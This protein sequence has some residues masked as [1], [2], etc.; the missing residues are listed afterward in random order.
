MS[1]DPQGSPVPAVLRQRDL[2]QDIGRSLS[3]LVAGTS[4]VV[5]LS[6]RSLAGYA[7]EAT[8]VVGEDGSR[9]SVL[10]PEAVTDTLEALRAVMY[11]EDSGTWMSA[12]LTVNANGGVDGDFN[13][14]NEPAWSHELDPELYAQEMRRF[15]RPERTTPAWLQDELREAAAR[16]S[17][18]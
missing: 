16:A 5:E 2:V 13:Y 15:P 3:P 1:N 10:A 18:P 8:H 14:D 7:E 12:L 4:R 9:E 11:N 6:T 17:G